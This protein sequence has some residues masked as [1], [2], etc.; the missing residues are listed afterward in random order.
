MAQASLV[1]MWQMVGFP[2]VCAGGGSE[3][4]ASAKPCGRCGVGLG[5]QCH[6]KLKEGLVISC[7]TEV[8][9]IRVLSV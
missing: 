4:I 5:R 3:A 2:K 8:V 1:V 7:V 6:P 9:R